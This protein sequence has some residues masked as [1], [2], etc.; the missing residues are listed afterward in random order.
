MLVLQGMEALY[1]HNLQHLKMAPAAYIAED[2]IIWQEWE[3]RSLVPWRLD[4]PKEGYAQAVDGGWM[5]Y[6]V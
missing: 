1:W 3:G 4:D 5:G 2:H 6:R